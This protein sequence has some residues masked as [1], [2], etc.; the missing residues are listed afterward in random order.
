MN[1]MGPLFV[2]NTLRIVIVFYKLKKA[3][4]K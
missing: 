3:N 1:Q 2:F 4:L